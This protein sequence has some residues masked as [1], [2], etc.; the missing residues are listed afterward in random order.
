MKKQPRYEEI[1]HQL[2]TDM[3][4]AS[5]LKTPIEQQGFINRAFTGL[6]K[7]FQE[8]RITQAEY[9]KLINRLAAFAGGAFNDYI[10]VLAGAAQMGMLELA[11]QGEVPQLTPEAARSRRQEINKLTGTQPVQPEQGDD[12]S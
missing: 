2:E 8:K 10:D 4:Q 7:A 6:H 5:N 1:R 11:I 9:V 3:L 12:E